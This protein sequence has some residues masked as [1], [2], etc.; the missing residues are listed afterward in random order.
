[1]SSRIY[2]V[3]VR[4]IIFIN[5]FVITND[6][7]DRIKY[8]CCKKR[9]S[10]IFQLIF[11]K[12]MAS[13][14]YYI[15]FY[16]QHLIRIEMAFIMNVFILQIN[17]HSNIFGIYNYARLCVNR[18]VFMNQYLLSVNLTVIHF[19]MYDLNRQIKFFDSIEI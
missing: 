11:V 18:I 6:T 1:M 5:S 14:I 3:D 19:I 7:E 10:R 4:N 15:I 9:D 12:I 8:I 2:L 17:K 16:F 13:K